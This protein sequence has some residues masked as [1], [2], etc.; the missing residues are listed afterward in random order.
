MYSAKCKVGIG[1]QEERKDLER[2]RAKGKELER[3]KWRD[4]IHQINQG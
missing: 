1:L 3:E 2:N 4:I